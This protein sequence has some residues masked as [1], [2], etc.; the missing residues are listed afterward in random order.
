MIF[1]F[2]RK[3]LRDYEFEQI[4]IELAETKQTL[5]ENQGFL[6]Q[7]QSK[8]VGDDHERVDPDFVT[9]MWA[10]VGVAIAIFLS[11]GPKAVELQ[12]H[13]DELDLYIWIILALFSLYFIVANGINTIL[14][15][16]KYV[17]SKGDPIY[18]SYA[19]HL[20]MGAILIFLAVLAFAF[21]K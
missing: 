17:E 6:L 13:T 20:T 3:Y 14:L 12:H 1:N 4:R 9:L 11:V 8:I 16:R 21:L 2:L 15:T 5:R 18:R 10:S 7:V 19:S